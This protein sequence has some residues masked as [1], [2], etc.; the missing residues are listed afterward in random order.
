MVN[1]ATC[2]DQYW[3]KNNG[4]DAEEDATTSSRSE[5][6]QQQQRELKFN[7]NEHPHLD[8]HGDEWRAI[9]DANRHDIELCEHAEKLFREEGD[10]STTLQRKFL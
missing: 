6:Q 1:Y 4:D 10:F 5:E 8:P 9:A 2:K 3:E 7:S